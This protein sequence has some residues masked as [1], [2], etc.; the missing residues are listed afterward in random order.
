MKVVTNNNNYDYD[1]DIFDIK[2]NTIND[3]FKKISKEK[4]HNGKF[5]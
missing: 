3:D 4:S 1:N 5:S 2:Y